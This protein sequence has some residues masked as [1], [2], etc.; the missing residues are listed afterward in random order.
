MYK[1]DLDITLPLYGVLGDDVVIFDPR[2]AEHYVDI[3]Q[4]FGIPIG[5]PKSFISPSGKLRQAYLDRV[6]GA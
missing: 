2:I 3:C 4:R 6:T 1:A 5:V